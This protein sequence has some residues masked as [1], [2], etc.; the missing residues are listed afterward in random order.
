MVSCVCVFVFSF[1]VLHCLC[2]F[3]GITAYYNLISI[4]MTVVM[5]VHSV[6]SN[7]TMN[8]TFVKQCE[9][10]RIAYARA[11]CLSSISILFHANIVIILL[12]NASVE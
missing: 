11:S 6:V 5:M 10:I 4:L 2:I 12:M 1:A 8:A 9:I 7:A 3:A